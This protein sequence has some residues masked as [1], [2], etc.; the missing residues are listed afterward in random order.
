MTHETGNPVPRPKDCADTPVVTRRV[1]SIG[2]FVAAISAILALLRK[3][4]VQGAEDAQLRALGEWIRSRDRDLYAEL[5]GDR[6]RGRP[7]PD[8][9]G[10]YTETV[11]VDGWVLGYQEA[12][13]AVRASFTA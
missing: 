2:T 10:E 5:A 6:S 7:P 13:D 1:F 3:T 12:R 4:S 11:V 8:R 9:R